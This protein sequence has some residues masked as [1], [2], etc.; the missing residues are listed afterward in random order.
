MAT[1]QRR[2]NGSVWV[3]TFD[4]ADYALA[5]AGDVCMSIKTSKTG[6]LKMDGTAYASADTNYADLWAVA[7]AAWKSGS[8]LTLPDMTARTPMGGGTLGATGGANSVTLATGNLPSHA[9]TVNHD[10]GSSNTGAGTSHAHT[11]AHTHTVTVGPD[12][13]HQ[14]EER[15]LNT[16]SA[17]AGTYS[18]MRPY[19]WSGTSQNGN[20]SPSSHSHSGNTGNSS[21]ADSGSESSHTHA[22]DMPAYTGNSGNAGS[23][24]AVDTTP[25]HLRVNFFIRY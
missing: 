13:S 24:T 17:N 1:R 4:E 3:T 12:G 19:G 5:E 14:H 10:H 2:W 16:I 23:G 20:S 11:I 9:H 8:T 7:P 6:W 21:A 18:M 25:A 22:F 15:Y